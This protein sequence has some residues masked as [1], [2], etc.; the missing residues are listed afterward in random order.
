MLSENN[1]AY[2]TKRYW[3]LDAPNKAYEVYRKTITHSVRVAI[4]GRSLGLERAIAECDRRES[5]P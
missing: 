1:I 3:V 4:I 2:E 5:V